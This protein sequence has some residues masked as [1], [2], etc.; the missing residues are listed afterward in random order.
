MSQPITST[1]PDT[2]IYYKLFGGIAVIAFAAFLYS[3]YK[4]GKT[5]GGVLSASSDR[6][7]LLRITGQ[8]NTT[9]PDKPADTGMPLTTSGFD[10]GNN[11]DNSEQ[12]HEAA[13]SIRDNAFQ[14]GA[15]DI[16]QPM[17]I[18]REKKKEK[19]EAPKSGTG[20]MPPNTYVGADGNAQSMFTV[21]DVVWAYKDQNVAKAKVANGDI[22]DR[23]SNGNGFGTVPY[24]HLQKLGVIQTLNQN[25]A[26]VKLSPEF[27]GF[28]FVEF[29]NMFKFK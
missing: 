2:K 22:I 25:G 21:G 6:K 10:E 8:G 1:T 15:E 9:E 17:E 4:D 19:T 14:K 16:A 7:E 28:G 11:S 23:D 12:L 20:K 13:N 24:K 29:R 27:R 3:K 5:K 18:I 26:Y